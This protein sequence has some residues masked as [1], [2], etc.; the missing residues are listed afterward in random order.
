MSQKFSCPSCAAELIFHSSHSV[1][2]SCPS[3]RSLVVRHGLDLENL[4]RVS[5]VMADTTVLQPRTKGRFNGRVFDVLG[6]VRVGWE[7]GFWNEWCVE[8][9]GKNYWLSEAQGTFVFYT[10]AVSADPKAAA[11]L[12]AGTPYTAPNGAIYEVT[13]VKQARAVG[14]EGEI[15]GRVEIG[16]DYLSVDLQKDEEHHATFELKND[17]AWFSYGQVQEFS[18]FHFEYLRRIDGW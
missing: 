12:L 7:D 5:E 10:E 18:E 1:Y 15:P 2:I 3:C 8:S 16:K 4:G 13:D 17:E 14:V 11:Q 6:R 9:D